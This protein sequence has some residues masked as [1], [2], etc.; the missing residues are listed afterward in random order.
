MTDPMVLSAQNAVNIIESDIHHPHILQGM[1]SDLRSQVQHQ[2]EE[3]QRSQHRLAGLEEYSRTLSQKL[4]EAKAR[5]IAVQQQAALSATGPMS[6]L[7]DNVQ[8]LVD[9]GI[10]LADIVAAL[11]KRGVE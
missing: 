3:Y 1:L 11:Q 7:M 4:V 8:S 6:R 9:S 5:L 2:C 10:S